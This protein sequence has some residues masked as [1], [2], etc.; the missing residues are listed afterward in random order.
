LIALPE[1]ILTVIKRIP[2]I[3]YCAL[4]SM[5]VIL[6]SRPTLEDE[7]WDQQDFPSLSSCC[8]LSTHLDSKENPA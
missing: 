3:R 7:A 4:M 2:K 5:A 1:Y 8:I 6:V